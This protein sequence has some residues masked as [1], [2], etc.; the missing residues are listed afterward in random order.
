M[1][2]ASLEDRIEVLC[3]IVVHGLFAR[4]PDCSLMLHRKGQSGHLHLVMGSADLFL[5]LCSFAVFREHL[6]MDWQDAI[7]PD[8][9]QAVSAYPPAPVRSFASVLVLRVA[10]RLL[11]CG[12]AVV[13]RVVGRYNS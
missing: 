7:R 11:P 2:T 5:A 12:T 3:L 4:P 9:N 1:V 13:V 8:H 10:R 6:S